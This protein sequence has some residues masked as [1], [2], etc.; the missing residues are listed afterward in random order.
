[1]IRTQPVA[2]QAA[3]VRLERLKAHS[4]PGAWVVRGR[5]LHGT[6]RKTDPLLE[7]GMYAASLEQFINT[8]DPE[9]IVALHRTIDAQLGLLR[10]ALVDYQ[11]DGPKQAE[12]AALARAILGDG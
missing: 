11:P 3:I 12:I 7:P 5:T 9:L 2:I 8:G 6:R 10:A 1:M 4:T